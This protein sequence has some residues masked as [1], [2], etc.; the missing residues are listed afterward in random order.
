MRARRAETNIYLGGRGFKA[1]AAALPVNSAVRRSGCGRERKFR[2]I[3]PNRYICNKLWGSVAN[4]DVN[5][6]IL[7][8]LREATNCF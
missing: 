7:D 5:R 6:S 1:I 4:D 2:M 8:L 3:N